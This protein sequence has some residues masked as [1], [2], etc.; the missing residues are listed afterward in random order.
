MATNLNLPLV[1]PLRAG[2]RG[3]AVRVVQER[4]NELMAGVPGGQRLGAD[5][6]FGSK[7]E[8]A[9]L[10]F[11]KMH[12]LRADGVVGPITAKALGFTRYTS[13]QR[14]AGGA[15]QLASVITGS[16]ARLLP[17]PH[18]DP[19]PTQGMLVALA[20]QAAVLRRAFALL[21][22]LPGAAGPMLEIEQLAKG[23]ED[24]LAAARFKALV[25]STRTMA[26]AY[27][28]S[29]QVRLLALSGQLHTLAKRNL[30]G[31]GAP[32]SFGAFAVEHARL[33]A[34]HTKAMR[35]LQA[36]SAP[37]PPQLADELLKIAADVA[38]TANRLL[39][40]V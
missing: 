40:N 9:V 34:L 5:G 1:G 27:A 37:Q 20:V 26:E 12:H 17:S 23:L 33:L 32:S 2:A 21:G 24:K 30:P 35:A 18:A 3:D 14:M 39:P 31:A 8:A 10:R 29:A 4:L 25:G 16:I 38:R 22:T 11:Q 28:A 36:G 15:L 7:T 19:D 6:A 13:L